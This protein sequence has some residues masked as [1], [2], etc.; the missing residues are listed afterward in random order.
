MVIRYA[1][2]WS[3]EAEAGAEEGTKDRPCAVIVAAT[4]AET[5][6]IRVVVAPI[7]HTPPTGSA[8]AFE[9]PPQVCSLLQ[10]DGDRQWL[11]FDQLNRFTWPGYD[12]RSIP[13]RAGSYQYGMLPRGLFEE[14][15]RRILELQKVRAARVVLRD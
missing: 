4:S 2:L 14:V 11:R 10:L 9:L 8:M 12:L 5:G 6:E 15:R 7:T 3:D 1:F 13:G